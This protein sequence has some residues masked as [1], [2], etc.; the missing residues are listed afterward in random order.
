M[1][2]YFFISHTN[3][4]KVLSVIKELNNNNYTGPASIL[5]KF[6]KLFQTTLSKPI[7]LIANLSFSTETFL[8]N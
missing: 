7:S 2:K 4:D 1:R 6:L 3:S 5:S 8:I